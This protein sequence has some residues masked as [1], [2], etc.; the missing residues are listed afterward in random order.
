MIM[1]IMEIIIRGIKTQCC[2]SNLCPS[3]RPVANTARTLAGKQQKEELS[4]FGVTLTD[5]LNEIKL[6]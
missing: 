3:V 6:N 4:Y 5:R 1:I 2:A